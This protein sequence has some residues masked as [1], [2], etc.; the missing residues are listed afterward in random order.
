MA[1]Q[2]KG[3]IEMVENSTTAEEMQPPDSKGGA[4]LMRSKADDLSVWQCVWLYKR[5][6]VISMIA[7]F[8]ASL[9][10][11]RKAFLSC[12]SSDPEFAR[13]DALHK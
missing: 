5:V 13:A 2:E 10:G 11:Y 3:N 1:Q 9:D 4:P 7:A 12:W 6:G 8:A